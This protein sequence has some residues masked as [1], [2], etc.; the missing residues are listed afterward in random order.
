MP[1][2]TPS[3][4]LPLKEEAIRSAGQGDNEEFYRYMRSLIKKLTDMYQETANV[5]NQKQD[6]P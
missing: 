1:K 3:F 6:A 4:P 2:L 5:V